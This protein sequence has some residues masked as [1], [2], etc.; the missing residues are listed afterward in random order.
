ME[1]QLQPFFDAVTKLVFVSG[2]PEKADAVFIPGS[3]HPEP[4][5]LAARIYRAGY[6]PVIIPS[7]R[8]GIQRDGFGIPG[9]DTEADWMCDVLRREGVPDSAILPEKN[10]TFTWENARFSRR[11]CDENG[12]MI[13]RGLLCCRPFHARR[14]LLYYQAAF[15]EAEWSACAASEEGVNAEDWFLSPEGRSRVLGE[16]RR[17]GD[18]I[19][20]QLEALIRDGRKTNR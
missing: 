1:R 7:G 6:T 16:L 5:R 2:A 14:A 15:P 18:Q 19:N 10:A 4:V 8:F 11:L 3:S 20:E 12:L 17:L 9:Y 13:R